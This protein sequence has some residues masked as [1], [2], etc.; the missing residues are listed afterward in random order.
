M[1]TSTK[2][3]IWAAISVL[4]VLSMVLAGCATPTPE[5]IIVK[6]T[7]A[8]KETVQV[9]VTEVVK[10]TTV[11]TQAVPATG[12]TYNKDVKGE[13]EIWHWWASPV[14][15]NAVKRILATCMVALPN[16]KIIDVVKPWGD[17]WTANIAAVAAGSGM[18]DIIVEDRPKLPQTGKD[19]VVTNL[20]PYIDRDKFDTSVFYPFTWQQ[21]LLDGKSYGIPFETDVR[22]MFYNKTMFTDEGLDA[23]KPP[24][25]WDELW[26]LADKLDKKDD[27]GNFTRIAFAPA[28]FGSA[29]LDMWKYTQGVEWGQKDGSV[30]VN[31]EKTQA[32]LDWMKKW[33]DRY[34][35]WQKLQDFKAK[36]GAA[37]NDPFMAGGIA[38]MVDVAGYNSQLEFYRPS[39]LLK[40]GKSK[41]RMEWGVAEMPYAVKAADWSGGFALSIP[42][43]AKDADAAWEVI[44]CVTSYEVQCFMVPGYLRHRDL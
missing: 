22:V 18:P 12:P 14:R 9:K 27:K 31:D 40:D 10:Q 44:K 6:E 38:M 13:V 7:V 1:K 35:G 17:V 26:A 29:G 33:V 32:T 4:V 25:T 37:P 23:T 24:K 39:Y 30:K 5:K 34:G 20:Q 21:T 11:V 16:I 43:G 19:G 2:G 15:R 3:V 28:V 36:F 42:K 8:V 41:P